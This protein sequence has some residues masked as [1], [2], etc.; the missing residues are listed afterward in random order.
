MGWGWG[1]VGGQ[2]PQHSSDCRALTSLS[3]SIAT[4]SITHAGVVNASNLSFLSRPELAAY[5]SIAERLGSLQAQLMT[6]KLSKVQLSLQGPLVSDPAVASA[7]KTS[8]L[9]GLLSVTQGPGAVNFINTPV[10]AAELGIEVVEKVSPKS[11]NYANLITVGVDTDTES[12]SIAASVFD[13][14]DA[15]LVQINGF[16]VT[17]EAG[18]F[19]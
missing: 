5:T 1:G 12:R 8:M 10:L 9:K 13:N 6:G 7:L 2:R 17:Y 3:L 19:L 15:R 11:L 18:E 4:P 14:S 16:N